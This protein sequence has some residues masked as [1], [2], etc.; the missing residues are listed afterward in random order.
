MADS[1]YAWW[2][3]NAP[4]LADRLKNG[5][6]V[7]FRPEGRSMEP[8]IMSGQQVTVSPRG[9]TGVWDEDIVFCCVDGH[10]F[11]HLVKLV[12][13]DGKSVLIGNN[14]GHVNG[15]TPIENVFGLVTVTDPCEVAAT[16]ER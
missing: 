10:Y 7:T 4:L 5:E 2:R 8:R 1:F 3:E 6:T 9:K 12:A 11:V 13:K 15:W 14:R 16:L